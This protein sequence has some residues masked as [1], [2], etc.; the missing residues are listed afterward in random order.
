MA[1]SDRLRPPL[2]PGTNREQ[3]KTSRREVVAV[4]NDRGK[5]GRNVKLRPTPR[6]TSETYIE[7][8]SRV[9]RFRV[10]LQRWI[11]AL[12]GTLGIELIVR[13]QVVVL[14]ITIIVVVVVLYA[15]Q[16]LTDIQSHAPHASHRAAANSIKVPLGAH[17]GSHGIHPRV[18][19]QRASPRCR[20]CRVGILTS[21]IVLVTL[22]QLG[23]TAGLACTANKSVLQEL[24]R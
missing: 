11:G 14:V 4:T 22:N 24:F 19:Q 7:P 18:V 1:L 15:T 20:L 5:G 8:N 13:I 23:E 12:Y 16:R 2:F 9:G 21:K 3:E 17:S 10:I 6:R